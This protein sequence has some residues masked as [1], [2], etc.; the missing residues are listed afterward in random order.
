MT[1][2]RKL[3][4]DLGMTNDVIKGLLSVTFENKLGE[5]YTVGINTWF[6]DNNKKLTLNNFFTIYRNDKN[7]LVIGKFL[8]LY[9]K[10]CNQRFMSKHLNNIIRRVQEY[11]GN[12]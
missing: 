5:K 7:E 3:I 2:E 10:V 6:L 9:K 8:D 1:A 11:E 12:I 4:K